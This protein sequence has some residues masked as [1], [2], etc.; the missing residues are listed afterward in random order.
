MTA[1]EEGRSGPGE[2]PEPARVPELDGVRGLALLL[3]V[4]WHYVTCQL[5]AAR[6]ADPGPWLSAATAAT[7]LAWSGVD[8]FFVLS[9]F[10]LGGILLDHRDSSNYFAVFYLRRLC[11]I[12]PLYTAWVLLFLVLA[13]QY[14]GG[15]ARWLVGRPFPA[16][17]YLTYTQ[18]FLMTDRGDFGPHWLGMTWSLAIEEQFYLVLPLLIRLVSPRVLPW[19]LGA[20]V[21][22]APVF[23]VALYVTHP[24]EGLGGFLLLPGRWD[25]LFTGVLVAW[26]LR[27]AG[28]AV[29][30][31]ARLRALRVLFVVLLAGATAFTA[32]NYES[33]SAGMTGVGH[34]WLAAF[35]ACGLVLVV[36]GPPGSLLRRLA[37][38]PPLR[39][40]GTV[41]YG[42]YLFHQGVSGLLH[43]WLRGESPRLRNWE[44]AGVTALAALVTMVLAE[45]S[46]RFFEQP[47]TRLG[48]RLRYE[49]GS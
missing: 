27:R 36:V 35:Y 49:R 31:R 26:F 16:W 41:S 20:L 15:A 21:A 47:L 12:V 32:W 38:S 28:A 22:S 17:A 1:G 10:L 13:L 48:H 30:L 34:T 5:Y 33:G 25:S 9:G 4:L 45:L 2:P 14:Q 3:V 46:Y 11:R 8:L 44:C 18:N 37:A 42:V 39:R 29:A 7:R 24:H 23:R 40:L 19:L 43:G 6:F